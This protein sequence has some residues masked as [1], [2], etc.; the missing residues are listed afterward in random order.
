MSPKS[1]N[2]ALDLF[3]VDY[4]LPFH[5]WK[6]NISDHLNKRCQLKQKKKELEV[7]K[8]ELGQLVDSGEHVDGQLVTVDASLSSL[9]KEIQTL[10]KEH[11]KSF[12]IVLDNVDIRVLASNMTSDDQNK[13]YHWCN[14]N[15][16]LDRVNPTHLPDD[17]PIADIQDVPNSTFLPSLS[18]HK[19]LLS[20]FVVLISRVLVENLPAFEIFKD[21]VPFHIQHKYS[22]VLK[23]KT[24]TVSI[25][26][27]SSFVHV[28][29]VCSRFN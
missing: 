2:K 21:V 24:E 1:I 7:R 15:T 17:T 12:S 28:L 18:D 13:D 9:Q 10:D 5:I 8:Y 6:D 16:Y 3:G 22:E 19:S 26:T 14:H 4:D 23:N 25:C 27:C 29:L 20:D 11:P